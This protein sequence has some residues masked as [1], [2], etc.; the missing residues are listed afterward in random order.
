M[1]R[2]ARTSHLALAVLLAA[3]GLAATGCARKR[4]KMPSG[5]MLPS[6]PIGAYFSADTSVKQ[7]RR[8]EVWA[9]QNPDDRDQ[10]FA[11]RL[12]AGPGDRVEVRGGKLVVNGKPLP[13]CAVGR[14]SYAEGTDRHEGEL[15]LEKLEAG[16]Y[17]TFEEPSA[18]AMTGPW[19]VKVG[20]WFAVGDNRSNSH[21]SRSWNGGLGGGVAKELLIG[22]V[23]PEPPVLPPGAEGLAAGFAKCK[24][25]LGVR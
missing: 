5:S 16:A 13:S 25:E 14:W 19:E 4:F 15:V 8:G 3:T 12:V 18:H 20:E 10:N 11:K 2:P 6:F 1:K 23:D 22:R 7:P 17:L 24:A 9:F 21:D